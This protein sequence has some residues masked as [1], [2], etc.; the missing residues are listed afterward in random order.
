MTNEIA[1]RSTLFLQVTR[2]PHP[3][4]WRQIAAGSMAL[5]RDGES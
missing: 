2:R 3:H 5:I 4:R 1:E